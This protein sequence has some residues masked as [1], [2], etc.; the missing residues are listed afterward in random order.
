MELLLTVTKMFCTIK[1]VPVVLPSS[2][3]ETILLPLQEKSKLDSL[4]EMV[5]DV[6]RTILDR[7]EFL[8]DNVYVYNRQ[9]KQLIIA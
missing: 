4:K 9:D 3:H 2:V 7:S 6:N 5:Y 8:S 1:D